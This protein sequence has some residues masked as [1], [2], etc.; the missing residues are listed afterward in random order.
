MCV[1]KQASEPMC[2]LWAGTLQEGI[3][4]RTG[5]EFEVAQVACRAMGAPER[6]GEVS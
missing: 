6:V 3:R 2:R 4:W 1:G 5:M